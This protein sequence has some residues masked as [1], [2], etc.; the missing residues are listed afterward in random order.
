M[1]EKLKT[2][3]SSNVI[4]KDVI[5]KTTNE[6]IEEIHDSFYTEVDKLLAEAKIF[7]TVDTDKQYLI[8]KRNRL[9][10]LGFNNT[11]EVQEA[12]IEIERLEQLKKENETKQKLINAIEYF[13]QKYPCYKF[14]TED[15][16]KKICAKYNLLYG[17]ISQYI[18]TV[19]DKNLEHIEQFKINEEDECWFY[20]KRNYRGESGKKSY[21]SA[22]NNNN[23][24]DMSSIFAQMAMLTKPNF[25]NSSF[26]SKC[27]LEIAAPV[28]DFKQNDKTE[29]KDYNISK[30]LEVPD[31]IVLQPVIY[32]DEKYYLVVTAWGQESNDSLVVNQ[33]MN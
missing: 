5:T 26:Q 4:T 10:K 9:V 14:I 27:R 3:L 19:P 30:K 12:E 8:D 15:S 24:N 28:K 22:P 32:K 21:V 18:G 7:R 1:F 20:V 11:Q 23:N 2:K 13:S 6:I 33:K 31:P 16:V 25:D 17:E 29:I